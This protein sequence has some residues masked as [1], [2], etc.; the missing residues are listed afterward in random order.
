[1]T[2]SAFDVASAAELLLKARG[3]GS[4]VAVTAPEPADRTAAR[5]VQEAVMAGL[6]DPGGVWKMA[7]LGGVTREAAILPR[8]LL[9]ETGTRPILPGHA[10]IEVETALILDRDPAGSQRAAVRG[11]IDAVCQAAHDNK[12]L[13]G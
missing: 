13:L 9:H 6:C 2:V 10:A 1:M 5:Q 8:A 3:Q 11:A 7:L 4:P 12:A